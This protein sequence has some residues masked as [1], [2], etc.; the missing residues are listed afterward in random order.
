MSIECPLVILNFSGGIIF[1]ICFT[2]V[3]FYK[4]TWTEECDYLRFC[5]G[6]LEQECAHVQTYLTIIQL[7]S[8][9]VKNTV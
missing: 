2:T 6:S 1:V 4:S 9:G 7:H 3:Y 5:I 8:K